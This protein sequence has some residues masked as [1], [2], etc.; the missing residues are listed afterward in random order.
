M[1]CTDTLEH[2]LKLK[3]LDI[4]YHIFLLGH[5]SSYSLGMWVFVWWEHR[6]PSMC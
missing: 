4:K 5:V 3:S 1:F 6:F 2:G